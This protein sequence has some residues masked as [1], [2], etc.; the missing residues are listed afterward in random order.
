MTWNLTFQDA[1]LLM[2]WMVSGRAAPALGSLR[3]AVWKRKRKHTEKRRKC[4]VK[5]MEEER[6]R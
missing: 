6:L 5:K 4:E 2:I 1:N 3:L